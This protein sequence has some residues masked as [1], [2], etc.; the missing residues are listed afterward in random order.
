[1]WQ[2]LEAEKCVRISVGKYTGKSSPGRR[3]H[4]WMEYNKIG[5]KEEGRYGVD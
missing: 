2:E 4:N 3:R 5:H 1:M